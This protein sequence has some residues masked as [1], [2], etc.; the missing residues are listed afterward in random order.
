M[1]TRH[2]PRKRVDVIQSLSTRLGA[3][4]GT[5]ILG[6]ALDNL[7]T[8]TGARAGVA[9]ISQPRFEII[10]E[11][12]LTAT[13]GTDELRDAIADFATRCI[14][15]CR[16]VR[17]TDVRS[18]RSGLPHA[19]AIASIG[20]TAALA[21]PLLQRKTA[22][23]ALVLLFPQQL[24]LNEET[25]LFV[26]TV[27]ALVAPALHPGEAK[28]ETHA[29]AAT[30]RHL[31]IAHGLGGATLL[32]KSVGHELSGPVSA[33]LLQLEEQRRILADLQIF[34]DGADTPLGGS[35][36]ELAELT[37]EL[38]ATVSKLRET[39]DQLTHLGNREL[40]PSAL[41][42]SEV[43][44]TACSVARPGFEER[45][46]ILESQLADGGYV[47]G[48]RE[49]LLQVVSDL[50]TLARDRAELAASTPRVV[51][52]T[53]NENSRV[54]LE[55]DDLGPSP[56]RRQLRDFDRRP[57]AEASSDEHRGLVLKLLGDV[58]LAHGGHVE[59]VS[60]EP[61]GTR[62]RVILPAFGAIEPGSLA[63][64]GV[65]KD[66][67]EGDSVI[68]N[69]LVVD[70]DPVFSRSARRA[71]KP[72]LVREANTASEA[73]IILSER[74]YLPDLVICDLMLPGAD[75][76]TLHRNIALSRPEAASRFLFVTGGTLGKETA[77][78]IRGSGCG[79]LRKPIDLSA[80][81]KHLSN[82]N[83]D[84]VT[85]SIVRTLR[86]DHDP[87]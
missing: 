11:Q 16:T 8:P 26:E 1:T 18:D 19:G 10:A 82:P 38:S 32:G 54:V 34:S 71:M 58:V 31:S 41:D 49:S 29:P 73:E 53:G 6:E 33:L 57:F 48:H 62:Y 72:H 25:V 36:A 59:L 67:L 68:R 43:A 76:T 61:S 47:S 51:V 83:R 81:R 21:V 45:G 79:A 27:A 3:A 28:P 74:S 78:Y 13:L 75:G 64:L 20:C 80:V 56:D 63:G 23:G 2:T 30:T 65:P 66:L 7:F 42:L 55:V 87:G 50:L 12:G 60:L 52:R 85:T 22:L 86:Q 4:G 14:D 44:R 77:D 39:T 70:D 37:D 24:D 84:P 69:V 17:F 5:A 46:I 35:I 15:E 9:V 40:A